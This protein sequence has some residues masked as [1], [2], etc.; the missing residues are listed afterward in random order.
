MPQTS[1]SSSRERL[2]AAAADLIGAGGDADASVREICMRA[3]VWPP[4]LY[5]FFGSK[6]GLLDAV[7]A[8]GFDAYI[9]RKAAV[10]TEDPLEAIRAGWDDHVRFGLEHPAFYV[11]MYG[12]AVPGRRSRGHARSL[13][14]LSEL[15][16]RAEAAGQLGV[17]AREAAEVVMAAVTGLTLHLITAGADD[18]ALSARLRDAAL[19]SVTRG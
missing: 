13:E 16:R 9:A 17:S 19:R 4:T 6:A 3:G 7:V 14:M 12:R 11:L 15:A 18:P 2:I 10:S 1:P 8:Q 5:H